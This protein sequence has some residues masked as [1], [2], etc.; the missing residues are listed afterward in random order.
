MCVQLDNL[1]EGRG[2]KAL[3]CGID[4]ES[5]MR[6]AKIVNDIGPLVVTTEGK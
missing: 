2:Q 3:Y 5:E 6:I 1:R 4:G